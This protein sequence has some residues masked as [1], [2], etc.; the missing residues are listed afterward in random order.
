MIKLTPVINT[1]ELPP[2]KSKSRQH[3]PSIADLVSPHPRDGELKILSYLRQGVCCGLYFDQGL[4]RDVLRA[5]QA[6]IHKLG[7]G[8][9]GHPIAPQGTYTDG[10]WVWWGALVYYVASYHIALPRPFILHAQ[11]LGWQVDRKSIDINQL[12]DSAIDSNC[13]TVAAH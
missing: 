1:R 13:A 3:L 5:T 11:Q 8:P 7:V 6:T 12:D 9:D 10:T 2:L 4:G